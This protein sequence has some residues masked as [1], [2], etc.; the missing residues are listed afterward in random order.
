VVDRQLFHRVFP[1][2]IIY[3]VLFSRILDERGVPEAEL[4]L[5]SQKPVA[6]VAE[7]IEVPLRSDRRLDEKLVR[8]ARSISREGCT[9][10]SATTVTR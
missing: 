6:A 4:A 2:L 9:S 3:L 10:R 8:F 1:R 5:G 7:S